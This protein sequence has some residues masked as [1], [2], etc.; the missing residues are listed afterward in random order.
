MNILITGA[1]GATGRVLSRNLNS[2]RSADKVYRTDQKNIDE[3]DYVQVDLTDAN[4][5]LELLASV[6]PDQIYHL[7]GSFSNDLL[8]DFAS[9]VLTTKNIFEGLLH[10]GYKTRVLIIGSSAE[11]GFVEGS[12]NP[13]AETH[14]LNPASIYGLTKVFQ[15]QLM[16]YYWNAYNVDVVMAR[17]FNLI[18]EGLSDRLFIGNLYSQIRSYKN[19]EIGDIILGS[20][21]NKRDYIDIESAVQYYMKIM[22]GGEA[23]EIYNVGSGSSETMRVILERILTTNGLSMDCVKINSL[24]TKNKFDIKD[25]YA[26]IG[27]V[28]EL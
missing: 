16:Q 18:G 14:P 28:M 17:T 7:A 2:T 13:I 15:T 23:G 26:D 24:M 1:L 21:E 9:N 19:G 25:M 4:K 12:D 27:K 10:L 6:K 22:S 20:L 5:V 8:T 3:Y 11:Y